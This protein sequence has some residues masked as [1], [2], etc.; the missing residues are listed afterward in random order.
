MDVIE[1]QLFKCFEKELCKTLKIHYNML[2]RIA[3]SKS[4]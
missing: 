3:Q 1:E 2:H 4:N